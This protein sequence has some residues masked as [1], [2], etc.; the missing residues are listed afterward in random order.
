MDITEII[1]E[2]HRE[3][4]RMFGLLDEID[5]KDTES[6]AAIWGRLKVLLEVHAAAEEKLFYPLLLN[7]G[8]GAGSADGPQDETEDAIGDHNEIRD[9]VDAAEQ[10]EVGSEQW[11]KGV[12]AAREANSDHMAEEEREAL[13]DFRQHADLATRHRVGLEFLV[14]ESR[15]SGGID[16]SDKDPQKFV[17]Q[18][19]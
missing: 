19:S 2:D 5:R 15:H 8:R 9:G 17:E 10:A 12:L 11:W 4:R 1:L 13:A 3:Q 7:K 18:H 6:L 16:S 14:Y